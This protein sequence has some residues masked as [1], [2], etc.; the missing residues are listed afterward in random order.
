ML[1]SET[2]Q[3]MEFAKGEIKKPV[4]IR[5]T[6][7]IDINHPKLYTQ[8]SLKLMQSIK[9]LPDEIHL[10]EFIYEVRDSRLTYLNRQKIM[11][12]INNEKYFTLI[13]DDDLEVFFLVLRLFKNYE[14]EVEAYEQ[15]VT[16]GM[17]SNVLQKYNI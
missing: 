11:I 13:L 14:N 5:Y 7:A 6:I 17:L 12:K 4:L 10:A 1:K 2:L 9:A 15:T 8:E 16:Q 3:I